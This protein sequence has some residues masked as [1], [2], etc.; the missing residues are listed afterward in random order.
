M[1]SLPD[2]QLKVSTTFLGG[3]PYDLINNRAI[4]EALFAVETH[5]WKQ[6]ATLVDDSKAFPYASIRT[7]W[8]RAIGAA[9]TGDVV[10]A[11]L[12]TT[13]FK[14]YIRLQRWP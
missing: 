1:T 14:R 2:R 11:R 4:L 5:D 12:M 7:Y 10:A 3:R 6:A 13:T 8:A 9:R